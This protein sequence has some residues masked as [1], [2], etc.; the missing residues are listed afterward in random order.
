MSF[1]IESWLH[2]AG[3]A[4]R[5]LTREGK[6]KVQRATDDEHPLYSTFYRSPSARAVRAPARVY[7]C[8]AGPALELSVL[9]LEQVLKLAK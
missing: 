3:K 2:T 8:I 4:E 1:K 6:G 7:D 9:P 5:M